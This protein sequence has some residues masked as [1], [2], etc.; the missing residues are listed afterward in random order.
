MRDIIIPASIGAT[1]FFV[2]LAI[3][4]ALGYYIGISAGEVFG[5]PGF[6]EYTQTSV[7]VGSSIG[8]IMGMVSFGISSGVV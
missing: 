6:G 8:L 2:V 5:T 1:M 7:V 3:S 4:V